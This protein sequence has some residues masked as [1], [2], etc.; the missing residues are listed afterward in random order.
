MF[1]AVRDDPAIRKV[2]L[3]RSRRLDLDGENV[4]VLPLETREGQAELAR[5][6]EILLDRTPR[7][8]IDMPL[9]RTR[10]HFVHLGG[11]LPLGPGPLQLVRRG[12]RAFQD[13]A[14]DYRRLHA[15]VVASRA[16]ALAKA[17][18]PRSNL[19][20]LWLTGLP[21][22]DLVARPSEA[23]PG[24]LREPSRPARPAGRTTARGAVA[25]AGPAPWAL[26][27]TPARLAGGLVPPPRRRPGG[28]RGGGRPRRQPDPP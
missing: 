10:H 2:V 7:A 24:D 18:S 15:M 1:E 5:C 12:S 13:L 20:Q 25:A 8:T 11:G 6:R 9:P 23:L 3:T 16:D 19:H 4:V 28:A 14:T 17:A 26:S 22:H 27:P 21:R